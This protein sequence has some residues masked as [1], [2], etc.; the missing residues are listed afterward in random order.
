MTALLASLRS[1]LPL[2]R[3]FVTSI[4][5]FYDS[6]NPGLPAAV[7]AYNAALPALVS[8]VNA[9]FVDI[10][11]ATGMCAPNNSTLD[12]LCAVCN[13][14]CGG[15]NPAVC[16]PEGFS[17]CHPSGAGYELVAGIWA[18]A[19]LDVLQELAAEKA[20]L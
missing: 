20:A 13:G 19:L 1:T 14:P 17:W 8:A 16:P 11:K 6:T 15:Y 4:L 10:N 9:T 2:A 18:S 3:I 5:S 7:Q 12:S